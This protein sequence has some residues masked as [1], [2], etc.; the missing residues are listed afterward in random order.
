MEVFITSDL[1]DEE[2]PFSVSWNAMTFH[3]IN[4]SHHY[5][6]CVPPYLSAFTYRTHLHIIWRDPGSS[7][8]HCMLP[9]SNTCHINITDFILI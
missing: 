7:G 2:Q 3:G 5:S 6:R 9:D 8:M 1:V 4:P